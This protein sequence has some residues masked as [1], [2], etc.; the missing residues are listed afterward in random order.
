MAKSLNEDITVLGSLVNGKGLRG[1][2][3]E[4]HIVALIYDSCESGDVTKLTSLITEGEQ[5]VTVE[6]IG[7][8]LT[9]LGVDNRPG[10]LRSNCN[11][12]YR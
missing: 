4:K 8:Y 5:E 10:V 12:N 6:V 7:K 1:L 9:S 3:K 11:V 2:I